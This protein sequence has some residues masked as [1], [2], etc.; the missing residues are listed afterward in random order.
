MKKESTFAREMRLLK[1]V[2]ANFEED[3]ECGSLCNHS[4]R[5]LWKNKKETKEIGREHEC[6]EE[7]EEDQLCLD[8]ISCLTL[9]GMGNWI[10][11]KVLRRCT[12]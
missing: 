8:S 5:S 6:I 2:S 11:E 1:I 7:F 10:S 9:M 3:R 4:K 12:S